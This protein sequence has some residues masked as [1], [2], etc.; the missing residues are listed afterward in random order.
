MCADESEKEREG[1]SERDRSLKS[2]LSIVNDV[3]N[4]AHLS[5]ILFF[6]DT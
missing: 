6:N 5:R 2:L 3:A 1:M 4:V